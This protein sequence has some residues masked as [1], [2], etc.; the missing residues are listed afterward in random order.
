[1]DLA[2]IFKVLLPV[3]LVLAVGLL[4]RIRRL[5][6]WGTILV[7]VLFTPI[8]GFLVALISG[9]KKIVIENEHGRAK[10]R[11]T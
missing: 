6:F 8:A 1:M 11:S 7:S 4:G 10:S 5:G 2:S 9:P 3:S